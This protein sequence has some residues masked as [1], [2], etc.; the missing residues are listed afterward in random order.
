MVHA[1]VE[2]LGFDKAEASGLVYDT[3]A[4]SGCSLGAGLDCG[5][6]S[7]G[8]NATMLRLSAKSAW[9]VCEMSQKNQKKIVVKE[10]DYERDTNSP[11]PALA[12]SALMTV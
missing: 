2:K 7:L 10:R 1:S 12:Y 9:F 6:R 3:A 11:A 5:D 8:F 4:A